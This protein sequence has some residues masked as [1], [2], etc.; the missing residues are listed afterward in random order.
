MQTFYQN[1]KCKKKIVL[2]VGCGKERLH[3]I[4]SSDIWREL[5]LDIDPDVKPDIVNSLTDMKSVSDASIDAIWSCH[6]LEY[7]NGHEILPALKE[8]TRVL[9][10]NGFA[11]MAISDTQAIAG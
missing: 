1:I 5:R 2:H 6:N 3:P 7:L 4:F 11:L 10:I 8:F 9:R